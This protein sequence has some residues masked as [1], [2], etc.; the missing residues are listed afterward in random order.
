MSVPTFRSAALGAPR[1]TF[2]DWLRDQSRQDV[3]AAAAGPEFGDVEVKPMEP[4]KPFAPF[5]GAPKQVATAPLESVQHAEVQLGGIADAMAANGFTPLALYGADAT[6]AIGGRPLHPGDAGKRVIGAFKYL[7]EPSRPLDLAE[8]RSHVADL[9]PKTE[10]PNLGMLMG[11]PLNDG[12]SV[13]AFDFDFDHAGPAAR[14]REWCEA[15]GLPIRHRG[16]S[17]FAALVRLRDPRGRKIEYRHT[18]GRSLKLEVLGHGTNLAAFG[19][20]SVKDRPGEVENGS[21]C[22]WSAAP[23]EVRADTVP[24]VKELGAVLTDIEAIVVE[25]GFT[26]TKTTEDILRE[27]QATDLREFAGLTEAERE[28]ARSR[29][30]KRLDADA[31]ILAPMRDGDKRK[32]HVLKTST[33]LA[34]MVELGIIRRDEIEQAFTA[35]GTD[36]PEDEVVRKVGEG[37]APSEGLD[38]EKNWGL[39]TLRQIQQQSAVA[40]TA[41]PAAGPLG[42]QAFDAK[43]DVL[44]FAHPAVRWRVHEYVP[45]VGT[46]FFFGPPNCGKTATAVDLCVAAILGGTFAGR[47]VAQLGDDE[48]ILIAT[49]EGLSGIKQRVASGFKHRGS[50]PLRGRVHLCPVAPGK[51]VPK[52]IAAHMAA[53]V[54]E[55]LRYPIVIIDTWSSSRMVDDN[56]SDKDVGDVMAE[57]NGIARGHSACIIF[58]DHTAKHQDGARSERG[59]GAKRGDGD[60]SHYVGDGEITSYKIK[61]AELPAGPIPF[62]TKGLDGAVVVDWPAE[63]SKTARHDRR[64]VQALLA[65][66]LAQ[67]PASDDFD[68]VHSGAVIKV[69]GD[70]YQQRARLCDAGFKPEAVRRGV[71][72]M[73]RAA[74]DAQ[75]KNALGACTKAN[76]KS[77]EQRI[78]RWRQTFYSASDLLWTSGNAKA[79]LVLLT[80]NGWIV[81]AGEGAPIGPTSASLPSDTPALVTAAAVTDLQGTAPSG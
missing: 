66:G 53:G 17:R 20:K 78:R 19:P 46:G 60:F 61:D 74:F 5:P 21:D 67:A 64:H 22:Q 45:M 7:S 40:A 4:F 79:P 42:K 37:L 8:R 16:G 43:H 24:L 34:P 38:N 13:V 1:V 51:N 63:A 12:T 33:A 25:G 18:D 32:L 31:K 10:N 62:K 71:F 81:P 39:R 26:P 35:S 47:A 56:N 54:A 65:A 3:R 49:S 41:T 2:Q 77:E 72:V 69:A 44:N 80:G 76:A 57:F 15:H 27:A 48:R 70:D 6:T 50:E 23:W 36:L 75:L 11:V 14:A 9:L 59:S 58:L 73:T 30:I 29:G 28:T 68:V 55:G 52:A